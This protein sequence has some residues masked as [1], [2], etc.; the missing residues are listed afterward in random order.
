MP[1]PH[2]LRSHLNAPVRSAR[3]LSPACVDSLEPRRLL[4]ADPA[5]L[6][7]DGFRLI[8]WGGRQVYAKP[9]R[10]V[11]SLGSGQEGG[12]RLDAVNAALKKVRGD[13]KAARGLGEE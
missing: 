7:A 1:K 9:G 10:W 12:Q 5:A 6:A 2:R 4:A 3:L 13:L 8:E 11:L